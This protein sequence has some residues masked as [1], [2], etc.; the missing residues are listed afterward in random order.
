MGDGEQ[1]SNN[2][3]PF[4]TLI[5]IF[6]V[7]LAEAVALLQGQIDT[8]VIEQAD[9]D[10]LIAALQ[11]AVVA[12]EL[13][14][15]E[16]E[17]D[18]ATLQAIQ[19]L[20]AQ[21]ID[22]LDTSVADLEVRVATNENDIAALVLV[23]QALQ[24]L[25]MAIQAQLV[26]IDARITAND[27]DINALQ[28]LST[29]LQ[30]QLINVQFQ[31]AAKQDRVFGIC[32]VGSSIR[33]INS[34]GSVVCEPDTVSSGVGT[35]DTFRS[36]DTVSIDSSI[37]FTRVVSNSRSCTGAYRAVGGGY[38]VNGGSLGFGNAYRSFPASNTTWT[39]TVVSD[40][41]GS[42]TLTTYV[43]CARVQ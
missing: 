3:Q 36:F 43:V 33:V 5:D 2:G 16:N 27:G 18:I 39:V 26:T 12:L 10:T 34:N 30:T 1:G 7:D 17:S 20:Q 41:V 32:P 15:S 23:D 37:I 38:T 19:A 11:S 40:S 21:L 9:Q 42:R 4:Q 29:S 24:Q 22:A 8:L 28:L 14:V 25:I 6:T 35:L 13:R 31:L